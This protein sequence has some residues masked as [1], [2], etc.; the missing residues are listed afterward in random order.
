MIKVVTY[1]SRALQLAIIATLGVGIILGVLATRGVPAAIPPAAGLGAGEITTINIRDSAV[2]TA[3]IA[4]GAVT[5]AKI[6]YTAVN[7]AKILDGTIAT[8]DIADEAVTSAKIADGTIATADLAAGA[9]TTAKIA[10]NAVTTGKIEGGAVTADKL[11]ENLITAAYIAD[12]SITENEIADDNIV[13]S[14]IV[15]ET[16][17]EAD[18]ANETITSTEIENGTISSD[19][20]KNDNIASADILDNSLLPADI[21]FAPGSATCVVATSLDNGDFTDIQ[22]AIDA[23]P[24][25]GGSVYIKEGTYTISSTITI[26]K[27]NVALIG[28]GSGTLITISADN[29]LNAVDKENL[30]IKNLRIIGATYG[31][32]FNRVIN[33]EIIECW[34]EGATTD[35]IKLEDLSENNVIANNVIRHAGSSGIA[36]EASDFNIISGNTVE[37]NDKGFYA[38]TW[39][40]SCTISNNTFHRGN[41]GVYLNQTTR[42]SVTGNIFDNNNYWGI[43]VTGSYECDITG[44]NLT[45]NGIGSTYGGIHVVSEDRFTITGNLVFSSTNDGIKLGSNAD[46]CLVSS[47]SVWGAT[48]TAGVAVPVDGTYNTI[49][50]NYLSNHWAGVGMWGGDN[51]S[52]L[53]NKFWNNGTHGIYLGNGS[54]NNLLSNNDLI[55]GGAITID[56]AVGTIY[57]AGNRL[58]NGDW[59]TTA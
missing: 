18:I 58:D 25:S 54:D 43:Y 16:I 50:G 20:I 59:R 49:I 36:L 13:S 35:G 55:A 15:D 14:H 21:E 28:A 46:Y 31:I 45:G 38:A 11:A 10:A 4:D 47:N 57:G 56:G 33:S 6:G 24:A 52:V 44:N 26:S 40:D 27:S 1:T 53:S 48:N 23:L 41:Y 17:T 3:K 32:N 29:A 12:N 51:N 30:L 8:A 19:D 22:T 37:N 39:S 34:I 2:T 42:T 5:S 9:V 7:S